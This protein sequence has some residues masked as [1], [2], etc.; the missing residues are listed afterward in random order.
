MWTGVSK[1]VNKM[2]KDYK[3]FSYI[4]LVYK[5]LIIFCNQVAECDVCQRTGRKISTVAPELHPIPVVSPWHHIGIDFI[6]PVSP[7]CYQG[8]QQ[9][10]ITCT[11]QCLWRQ[12]HYRQNMQRV[13]H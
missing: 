5:N 3:L 6:G 1:D 11:S 2:V 9:L 10:V 7:P 12:S 4:I 13:L 8:C